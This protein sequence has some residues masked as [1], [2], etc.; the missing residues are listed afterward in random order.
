MSPSLTAFTYSAK[1][2]P[3]LHSSKGGFSG[4]DVGTCSSLNSRK[5]CRVCC[6]HPLSAGLFFR[7]LQGTAR[8]A[9]G[10]F[11]YRQKVSPAR[12][13][14][15]NTQGVLERGS[16]APRG[17]SVTGTC[18]TNTGLDR[19][20]P[21]RSESDWPGFQLPRSK[22]SGWAHLETGR[23]P[24]TQPGMFPWGGSMGTRC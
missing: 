24:A 14:N 4:P 1:N 15:E 5:S 6:Y 18:G 13:S 10:S 20:R 12:N 19:T 7:S 21:D 23:I 16:G 8:E 2:V 9:T 3:D 11:A 17:E 22:A